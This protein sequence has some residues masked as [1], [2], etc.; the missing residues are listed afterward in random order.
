MI[1]RGRRRVIRGSRSTSSSRTSRRSNQL[2]DIS[3]RSRFMQRLAGGSRDAALI[4]VLGGLC[5]REPGRRATASR[6]SRRSTG[7]ASEVVAAASASAARRPPGCRA[8]SRPLRR[9]NGLIGGEFRYRRALA[10]AAFWPVQPSETA[11]EGSPLNLQPRRGQESFEARQ[12]L[13]RALHDAAPS[14]QLPT[15]TEVLRACARAFVEPRS[16][17]AS[18]EILELAWIVRKKPIW[19][20]S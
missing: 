8:S 15:D 11:A 19:S 13:R 2:I 12:P 1:T 17:H 5:E 16:E 3:G 10:S 14:I 20:T 6:S 4:P 7:S 9:P 18:A